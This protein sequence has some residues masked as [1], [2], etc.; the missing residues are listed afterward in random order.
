[1]FELTEYLKIKTNERTLLTQDTCVIMDRSKS[2][3]I[4]SISRFH[5]EKL[6]LLQFACVAKR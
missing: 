4:P 5:T 3:F 6:V 1:M 2:K